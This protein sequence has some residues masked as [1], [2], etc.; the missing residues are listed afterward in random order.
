MLFHPLSILLFGCVLGVRGQQLSANLTGDTPVIAQCAQVGI[1]FGGG[2]PPYSFYVWSYY[3]QEYVSQSW[4]PT[5][6]TA[7]WTIEQPANSLLYLYIADT[8]G[9][10]LQSHSFQ[11][12]AADCSATV[13]EFQRTDQQTSSSSSSSTTSSF[14]S[15]GV[16]EP[17]TTPTPPN[18]N[19]PPAVPSPINDCGAVAKCSFTATSTAAGSYPQQ[20]LIG[21]AFDNCASNETVTQT[22]SGSVTISDNWSVQVGTSFGLPKSIQV[23]ASV[24]TGKEQSVTMSQTYQYDTPPRVRA[25]LVGTASFNAIF[26]NMAVN[27]PSG[28]VNVPDAV[29]FQYNGQ[30]PTVGLQTIGCN[31][32]WPIW[33]T[34]SPSSNTASGMVRR[35]GWIELYAAALVTL[36]G[37]VVF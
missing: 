34:T 9:Y 19:L 18:G 33:N 36:L 4:T 32:S 3:D 22:F 10:Y 24:T 37:L 28:P 6:G 17:P 26:G 21:A 8:T 27:Y 23:S 15:S 12:T 5:P 35:N 29:F 14:N 25:A 20:T 16:P 30:P 2:S 31:D 1:T 7:V 13:P 11:V